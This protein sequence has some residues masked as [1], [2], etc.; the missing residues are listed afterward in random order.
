M[1]RA[2]RL[3]TAVL[4]FATL[5]CAYNTKTS[6]LLQPNE[7]ALSAPAGSLD[8]PELFGEA[9]HDDMVRELAAALAGL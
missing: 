2:T 8:D 3:A 5:C 9:S 1:H 7:S 4:G 6:M